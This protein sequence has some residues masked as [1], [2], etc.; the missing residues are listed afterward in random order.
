M[1][2]AKDEV[3]FLGFD[4]K[5]RGYGLTTYILE[6]TSKIFCVSSNQEIQKILGV[7]NL[8]HLQTFVNVRK[9]VCPNLHPWADPPQT[10]LKGKTLPNVD[11]L[12][13]VVTTLWLYVLQRGCKVCQKNSDKKRSNTSTI[14]HSHFLKDVVELDFVGPIEGIYLLV[15]ID[16]FTKIL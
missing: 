14:N 8:A 13:K 10:M 2:L 4:V 1:Q 11:K 12:Q 5:C 6:Q 15:K 7:L 9:R 16:I 3:L